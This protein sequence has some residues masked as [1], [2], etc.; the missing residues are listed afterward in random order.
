MGQSHCRSIVSLGF[1]EGASGEEEDWSA[2]VLT[3]FPCWNAM[4]IRDLLQ[5]DA[6]VIRD[7]ATMTV[8]FTVPSN[9]LI[10]MLSQTQKPLC[11]VQVDDEGNLR[12]YVLAVHTANPDE[13][14]VWQLGLAFQPRLQ[15]FRTAR[16]LFSSLFETAASCGVSRA[17]CSVSPGPRLRMLEKIVDSFQTTT[18]RPTGGDVIADDGTYEVEYL[19]IRE[20]KTTDEKRS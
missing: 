1:G 18:I 16:S 19:I 2:E 20:R 9:Y 14:F 8:G 6:S 12:G 4:L 10:W 17:R 11:K 13:I 15:A 7:I 3:S 5:E